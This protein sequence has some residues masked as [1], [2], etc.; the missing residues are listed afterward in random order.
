[1]KETKK[2]SI[3]YK[4]L[5]CPECE[6]D[7]WI[8]VKDDDINCNSVFCD[9]CNFEIVYQKHFHFKVFLKMSEQVANLTECVR[10]YDDRAPTTA[11]YFM[12]DKKVDICMTCLLEVFGVP[13][14]EIEELIKYV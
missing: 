3:I 8:Y 14:D 10:C 9:S 4:K 7:I 13:Q 11:F 2:D 12:P 6:N 5:L 1:M